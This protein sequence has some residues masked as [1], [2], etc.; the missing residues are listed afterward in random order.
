M[1]IYYSFRVKSCK[2][3]I[4]IETRQD[5]RFI[6][7]SLWLNFVWTHFSLRFSQV[8]WTLDRT[9]SRLFA[10]SLRF[11]LVKDSVTF[12]RITTLSFSDSGS[13]IN[14]FRQAPTGDQ[15]FLFS[16][17]MEKCS[18]QKVS[19]K[20]FLCSETQGKIIGHHIAG[21]NTHGER[22][23]VAS[24]T[25]ITCAMGNRCFALFVAVK[26]CGRLFYN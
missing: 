15:N 3:C 22:T 19:V 4:A 13:K 1:I 7:K 14:F 17:Q 10:S 12:S 18:R 9:L 25:C 21:I 5:N 20:L 24:C 6:W 2:Y 11:S 16:R 26:C 8:D 23:H